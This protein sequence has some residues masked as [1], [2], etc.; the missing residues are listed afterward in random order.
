MKKEIKI[1]LIIIIAILLLIGIIFL[2][3]FSLT[4]KTIE[5]NPNYHSYTKAICNEEN[6]C[7]D[8]IVECEEEEKLSII[9]TGYAIQNPENWTDKRKEEILCKN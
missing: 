2:S 9:S 7:E 8:Y 5:E 6:Y 4:G 3:N 1:I